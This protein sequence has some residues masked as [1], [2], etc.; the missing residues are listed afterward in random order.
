MMGY[1]FCLAIEVS[2]LY[3]I[4]FFNIEK[5]GRKILFYSSIIFLWIIITFRPLE[6]ADTNSYKQIFERVD[7]TK[8]YGFVLG[9]KEYTTGV[10]YGF[11]WLVFLIKKYITHSYRV[12][13][14]IIAAIELALL[15]RSISYLYK[16]DFTNKLRCLYFILPYFGI[17]Y[18]S[19]PIRVGLALSICLNTLS[20]L[21][22][23][24]IIEIAIW[25]LVAFSIHRMSI[26]FLIFIIVYGIAPEL[27]KS[28]YV[29]LWMIVGVLLIIR[30]SNIFS[31][32]VAFL[33]QIMTRLT[34]LNYQH[35]IS[36]TNIYE[37]KIP[38]TQIF[39]WI[40]GCLFFVFWKFIKQN[41]GY[42]FFNTYI[43]GMFVISFCSFIP[44]ASRIYD[45]FIISIPYLMV[46]LSGNIRMK[47]YK[48]TLL[49]KN[50]INITY[51]I[52]CFIIV[53]RIWGAAM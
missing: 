41:S 6:I 27:K 42:H 30:N 15:W 23:K 16:E 3:F 21:R 44:G 20:I 37:E 8:N 29:A 36:D 31:F 11:L 33:N 48:N 34:M 28:V 50:S 51:G 40:I 13:F 9:A 38:L 4:A 45:F 10:E 47:H 17:L 39:F 24:K 32:T 46:I 43:I 14:A 26:L 53:I 52:I 5:R 12:F 1:I 7:I 2:L 49:I 25:L 35:Y 19:T 18:L 22:K